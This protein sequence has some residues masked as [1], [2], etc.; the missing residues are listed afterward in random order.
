M[1]SIKGPL[2]GVLLQSVA[3][4]DRCHD[5]CPDLP[6]FP[7]HLH[8]HH[9]VEEVVVVDMHQ[10]PPLLVPVLPIMEDA[11]VDLLHLII[12]VVDPLV[13]L[14]LSITIILHPRG[15]LLVVPMLPT[16]GP[17]KSVPVQ[18]RFMWKTCPLTLPTITCTA[19][20][21]DLVQFARFPCHSVSKSFKKQLMS[22]SFSLSNLHPPAPCVHT[23][24]YFFLLCTERFSLSSLPLS[25]YM[26]RI[27][28]FAFVEF[29]HRRDA[30]DAFNHF[31]GKNIEG[32]W[33]RC[34]WDVAKVRRESGAA[35]APPP[36]PPPVY[37]EYYQG[38]G[39]GYPY[40][41]GYGYPGYYPPPP[42]PPPQQGGPGNLNGYY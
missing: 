4:R 10:G 16:L 22:Y 3:R 26:G 17:Q 37:N 13:H 5:R 23:Y 41:P 24:T 1:L 6:L 14:H 19:C 36:P 21:G 11:V 31:D 40:Y 39:G 7:T 42:P 33:L 32:R 15:M 30:E 2:E 29:E 28:G 8:L 38:Y 25:S 18:L 34:D 9:G 12:G 27:K 35:V 20:L